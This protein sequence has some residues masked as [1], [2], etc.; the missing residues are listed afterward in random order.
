[1]I[2]SNSRAHFL[3]VGK[4]PSESQVRAIFARRGLSERLH[5][6]GILEA[7]QL[8]DAYHAMDVFAFASRSETQGMVLTEAMAAGVPVVALDAPGIREVVRDEC[9]GRLLFGEST[10]TLVSALQWVA[11]LPAARRQALQQCARDT[12]DDFSMAHMAAKALACYG[13]LIDSAAVAN[14][15]DFEHWERL[16]HLFKAEWDIARGIA[17]A[18]SAALSS[19][20]PSDRRPS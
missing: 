16:L 10:E 11:G 17:S 14:A 4:G 1:F 2:E 13:S 5:V 18:T 6:A 8:V 20:K 7:R 12:A 3:V 9:N 15:D 19:K